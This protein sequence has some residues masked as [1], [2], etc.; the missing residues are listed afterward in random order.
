M[1]QPT[2]HDVAMLADAGFGGCNDLIFSGHC[3]FW[4]LAPLAFGSYYRPTAPRARRWAQAATALLWVALL[5][6]RH[7]GSSARARDVLSPTSLGQLRFSML[8]TGSDH[9][10]LSQSPRVRVSGRRPK[11]RM[12]VLSAEERK[13][14]AASWALSQRERHCARS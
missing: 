10:G 11:K 7:R 3:A 5:Q 12:P 14:Q 6:A 1:W 13:D 4:A 9:R 8:H 2:G